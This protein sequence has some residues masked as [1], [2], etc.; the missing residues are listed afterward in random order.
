MEH[1][2][3]MDWRTVLTYIQN[4]MTNYLLEIIVAALWLPIILILRVVSQTVPKCD[5]AQ[6]QLDL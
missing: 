3:S 6:G 4:W 5:I 1:Y 2:V